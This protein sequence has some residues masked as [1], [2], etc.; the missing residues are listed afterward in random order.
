MRLTEER[1]DA[2]LK[3]YAVL[4]VKHGIY[5]I[6]EGESIEAVSLDDEREVTGDRGSWGIPWIK[7]TTEWNQ[8]D[9]LR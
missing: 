5:L 1:L 2:F 8:D 6:S 7:K 9:G 4:C 3:E